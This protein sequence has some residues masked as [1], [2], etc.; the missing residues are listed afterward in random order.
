MARTLRSA[1]GNRDEISIA[2]KGRKTGKS[3]TLPVWFVLERGSL[4]LL[5]VQ[6]SRNQW[7]RNLLVDPQITVRA[8]RS[9][10]TLV[11]RP[12]QNRRVV[13]RIAGKFRAKYGAADVAEYYSR[14]DAAVEVRLD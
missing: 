8:G 14:F 7:F 13:R 11:A 4:W 10:Q 5:P 12:V 2:V 1:L 9:R 3:I 6:G